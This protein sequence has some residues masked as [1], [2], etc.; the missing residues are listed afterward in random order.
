MANGVSK[1]QLLIDLRNRLGAGLNSARQQVERATGGMQRRLDAFSQSNTRLFSAIEDRVPGVSGALDM[2][3]NPY[4]LITAAVL[5]AGMAMVKFTGMANDWKV[6]LAEINVTA[7]MTQTELGGLS[8][9]LLQIGGRNVAPLEEIPKAFNRIISAGLSVNDSLATL[10]PTLRA[11]KAGF[12]DVE[13]VAAAAVA[14]MQSSGQDANKVYD[15]LFATLNK[16]NA[17]FKDI[18]QYLPKIIPVAR[19]VGFA[20]DETAGA[21][22]SLTTKLSAEASS[23]ALEG[24]MRSFSDKDRVKAFKGI[25]V[26]IFDK[27]GMS[28]S[29]IDIMSDL[30]KEMSGLTDKQRMLKFGKLG[31]DQAAVLGLSTL[32]QDM[33]NLKS[34]IDATVNSQGALNKAYADAAAPFDDF[35]Q[36]LNLIKVQAIGIGTAILPVLS[37]IGKGVLFLVQN[38]DIIGGVLGGLAIAWSIMNA[39]LILYAAING[40]LAVRTGIATAAQWAFNV[41]ASANPIGL[42]VLAIGALIGGLVVAYNKF[43]KFREMIQITWEVIKNLASQIGGLLVDIFDFNL[44]GIKDKVVNFKMPDLNEIRAKIKVDSET[45]GDFAGVNKDGTPVKPGISPV[46]AADAKSIG[47]GSQTKSV[48]I[49]IDSFVKGFSPTSQSINGMNKDELERWMTEMFMRVV[50]SAE[51][52]M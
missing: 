25:G 11:A 17:K 2:L 37:A 24:I 46:A 5:T 26:N 19:N 40:I 6:G 3:A 41:A 43:D 9:K 14:T 49:N 16:G 51:T 15:V 1:L 13:T 8:D 18:A 32:I 21:Y 34:S 29:L 27:K 20:L 48:T 39:K 47:T 12:T 42:I 35:K 36:V 38:L 23:T 10:E 30:E 28:R 44:E 7:G 45:S 33:P 50:R 52:A 31:L 4:V 22:A